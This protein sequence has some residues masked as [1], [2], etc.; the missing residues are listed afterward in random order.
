MPGSARGKACWE[1]NEG[2][3]GMDVPAGRRV[4]GALHQPC[5]LLRNAGNGLGLM[6]GEGGG[7]RSPAEAERGEKKETAGT[8]TGEA[9]GGKR[10]NARFCP[11]FLEMQTQTNMVGQL[12]GDGGVGEMLH[13]RWKK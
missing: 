9:G 5:T 10:S 4:V 7:W 11:N 3:C 8:S 12:G 1:G 13:E 6:D 2:H